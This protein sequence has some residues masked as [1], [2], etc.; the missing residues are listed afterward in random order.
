MGIVEGMGFN[1]RKLHITV[2]DA[3]GRATTANGV[4]ETSVGCGSFLPHTMED[5][6]R[7]L[8]VFAKIEIKKKD[9]RRIN[10][11]LSMNFLVGKSR[12]TCQFDR[13]YTSVPAVSSKSVG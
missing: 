11:V 13:H 1:V 12:F 9:E 2:A 4:L 8:L 7:F 10:R 5:R 6:R 3:G